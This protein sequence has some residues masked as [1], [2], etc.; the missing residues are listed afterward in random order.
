MD[1]QV[2]LQNEGLQISTKAVDEED[3]VAGWSWTTHTSALTDREPV[4]LEAG[5]DLR[6]IQ[7]RCAEHWDWLR[8]EA[9]YRQRGIG[10]YGFPWRMQQL[11]RGDGEIVASFSNDPTVETSD[12][13]WAEVLNAALT[14]VPL[15]LPDDDVLGMPSRIDR[16]AVVG[17]A[18]ETPPNGHEPEATRC[19]RIGANRKC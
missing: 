18:P 1:L 19:G 12:R 11:L 5:V 16:M 4:G 9:L 10:G 7:A 3:Q 6:S 8:V 13:S 2:V 17:T 14:I 15:L